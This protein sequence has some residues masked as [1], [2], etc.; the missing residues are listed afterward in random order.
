MPSANEI[1][2][3]FNDVALELA[4]N[5]GT[6]ED[7]LQASRL[8][9]TVYASQQTRLTSRARPSSGGRSE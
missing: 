8:L 6:G 1:R 3:I 7:G 5:P 9:T 2:K 4:R